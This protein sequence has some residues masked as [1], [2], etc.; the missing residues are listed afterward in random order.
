MNANEIVVFLEAVKALQV[1]FERYES[2]DVLVEAD[3]W[4]PG[5]GNYH[6]VITY[7]EVR[8]EF[9]TCD[10]NFAYNM[11]RLFNNEALNKMLR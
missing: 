3:I 1:E 9:V 6:V 8:S 10:Y 7:G 2:F 4:H 11:Q 5:E